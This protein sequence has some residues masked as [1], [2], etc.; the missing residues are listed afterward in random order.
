MRLNTSEVS[1]AFDGLGDRVQVVAGAFSWSRS[2]FSEVSELEVAVG[3]VDG[4]LS[5][6]IF[7]GL[8]RAVVPK[9]L[10]RLSREAGLDRG[11]AVGHKGDGPGVAGPSGALEVSEEALDVKLSGGG[12]TLK[13]R[14]SGSEIS[15]GDGDFALSGKRG[16]HGPGGW[17]FRR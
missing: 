16:P 3:E 12:G 4:S 14:T 5:R 2:I 9:A 1:S 15:I 13:L 6:A 7:V 11:F 10:D 8:P 17:A